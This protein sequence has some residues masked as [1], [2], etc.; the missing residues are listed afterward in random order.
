[1]WSENPEGNSLPMS[2]NEE[3]ALSVAWR[4]KHR[5]EDAGGNREDPTGC[6]E[7]REIYGDSESREGIFAMATEAMQGCIVRLHC[8]K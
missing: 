4:I 8:R 7:T 2:C 1:M 6:D 3:W 5:A